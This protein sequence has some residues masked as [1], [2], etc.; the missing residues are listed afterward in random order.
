MRWK[1]FALCF[2]GIACLL[3]S[4]LLPPGRAVWETVDIA[5][6]KFLNG[7]LEGHPWAQLFWAL[8]N[9]KRADMIETYAVFLIFLIIGV[10]AAPKSERLRRA[11][12]FIFCILLVANIIY[13]VNRI[14]LREHIVIPRAS[15]S[16]VVTPCVR[17]S[18]EIP[19]L[20]IKDETAASFPGDHATTLMLFSVLYTFYAGK[21]LGVYACLYAAFRILPRLILGAHWFSDIV[22]G[23]GSLV[24][25]FLALALCTPFHH[26]VIDRIERILTLWK[27]HE[28]QKDSV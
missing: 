17:V 25:F 27:K 23:S 15:P 8:V 16:L 4:F 14:L 1:P 2:L 21:R 7:T 13:F 24:L 12:Q 3:G 22:V 19:W 9:H 18:D 11:A 5:I 28:V 20:N 6:F 26:W 10:V